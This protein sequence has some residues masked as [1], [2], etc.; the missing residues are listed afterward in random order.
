MGRGAQ[1]R[2]VIRVCA[3]PIRAFRGKGRRVVHGHARSAT[4]RGHWRIAR[5]ARRGRGRRRTIRDRRGLA[6]AL[7]GLRVRSSSECSWASRL[8][9]SA[10]PACTT[11][12]TGA[13]ITAWTEV[14][15]ANGAWV[16]L[17]ATP[18][19]KIVPTR[20]EQGKRLPEN[21][22]EVVQPGSKVLSHRRHNPTPQSPQTRRRL[23][24][25]REQLHHR[26]VDHGARGSARRR[27]LRP[28]HRGVSRFQGDE[29]P[30]ATPRG[31][32]R[33]LDVGAWDELLDSYTDL[34]IEIPR[35]LT[36][37][38]LGDVLARPRRRACGR[39]RPSGIR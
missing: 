34:G 24:P 3:Q 13:N 26:H 9:S 2:L 23:R 36:R 14:R 5:S 39:R 16:A 27:A 8:E 11:V 25:C 19:H 35:G 38:E 22:T 17:D 30:L 12:C 37:A 15:G 33:G 21:P 1:R 32:R 6:R 18:Q 7:L 10:V 29:A 20:I 4:T 28:A 31:H